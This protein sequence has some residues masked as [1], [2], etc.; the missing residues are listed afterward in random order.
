VR[1]VAEWQTFI[2]THFQTDGQQLPTE[3]VREIEK[4]VLPVLRGLGIVFG[5][6]LEREPYDPGIRIVLEC[7]PL[8]RDLD[9]IRRTLAET[10][11]RIPRRP[12]PIVVRGVGDERAPREESHGGRKAL[13]GEA[14]AARGDGGGSGAQN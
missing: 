11:R 5:I 2:H 10:L 1:I 12:A 14:E 8:D 4:A 9:V 3:R 13:L 7:R 6:H